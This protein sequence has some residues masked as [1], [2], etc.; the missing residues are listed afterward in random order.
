MTRACGLSI[1]ILQR[2]RA[3]ANYE[4]P[5][6]AEDE[7]AVHLL[8]AL[9]AGRWNARSEA[10]Q[11]IL[12][13]LAG[14]A[15]Y[16]SVES[17]LHRFLWVDEPP[18]RR[19]DEMWTLTSAAD[20]FQLTAWRLTGSDLDRFK[21]AFREVFG[22]I[23]PK[24]EIPLDEWLYFD[25]RG[26]KGHSGW[27][28]SGMAEALLLIAERGADAR[29]M[30]ARQPRAYAEEVVRGLP[31]LNDDWRVLAS[32][33]D[34]YPRLVEAAPGPLLDSLERLAKAKPDDVRRL[35]K[36]G[37]H[38]GE[39]SM[40][41]GLLWGLETLAWSPA[42][43]PRV[44][45]VLAGLAR[46]D[47]GGRMANRPINS[48]GEIFSW[49]HPGTNAPLETRLAA[50]DLI[51]AHEPN[52]GWDLLVKLLPDARPYVSFGTA[53][54]RWRD[55]GDLPEDALTRGGQ[56]RFVS[57]IVDRALDRVGSD[58]ARWSAILDSLRLLSASQQEK[59]LALLE[60]VAQGATPND[61][62][63]ALWGM[64]RD[65]A[66]EHRRFRR[67]DWALDEVLVDRLEAILPDL[68]PD[69][70]VERNRWLFDEWLPDL[71]TDEED[72]ERR[73]EQ[74]EELRQQAVREILHAQEVEGL[75]N[76][77]TICK[78]PVFVASAAVPLMGN[79][80]VVRAFVERAISAGEAGVSLAGHISRAAQQ[81]HGEAWRDV[82]CKEAKA[83]TWPPA[84]IAS[85]LIWWPDGRATWDD[86]AVLGVAAEYWRRKRV[87]VI[88]GTTEEQIYQIDRL[89]EVGRA[90][91]AFDRVAPRGGGVPTET[92]VRL[93][94]A[95]LDELARVQTAEE[96]RQLGLNSHDVREFLDELRKRADLPRE[97]LARREYQALPLLGL[98]NL[99]GLTIHEFMA[100]DPHF[101]VDIL[102][103]VFLP[104]HRDK[105]EADES[106]P[107]AQAR[108]QAAFRLLEGMQRVPGQREDHQIDEGTLLQWAEAVRKKAAEVDRAAVADL[109]IG[110]MLA[111]SP[112]D[113][114]D[115]GWPHRAVRN[116]IEKLEAD[117]IERGL[118]IERVSMRGVYTKDLYEGGAQERDL[119]RQC[120]DWAAVSRAHWP[121]MAR[122]LEMMAQIWEEH[123][124]REDMEAEQM[125]LH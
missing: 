25:I 102:C 120:R 2:Q 71:P 89:I 7:N 17:Q 104:A 91:E 12:R 107:E 123:A 18:L 73:Q 37:G 10:D 35:F 76:L 112:E 6:W 8:P 19:I 30:Y 75:V 15:D 106:T 28:R 62:K 60:A 20:A 113:P 24:V 14:A 103:D 72:F 122:V 58:P 81:L 108:A 74:V 86:A 57:A 1:T 118:T 117:D 87:L 100:E 32:L 9:L 90:P 54:P 11:G 85:L 50:I 13:P 31:G 78:I 45:L 51:L 34:Q 125:K 61:T 67:A 36:E 55:F 69:N 3:P 29:L 114:E 47:P 39:G 96:I 33:R 70:P 80:G 64:L 95:T 101:F 115:A 40:H 77:G 121:R 48:L 44:T 65:F 93:F 111:H 99:Q 23:D 94:D 109:Q 53:K 97:E 38:L 27:L 46:I 116:V 98:L 92:L 83:G 124:Q 82:V 5:R 84:V 16:A 21:G 42:Y 105:S 56:I 41:T 4:R 22:R 59:T 110:K 79:L 63:A 66:Y 88:D 26:E 49:W 52:T 68:A 43:L 119:A